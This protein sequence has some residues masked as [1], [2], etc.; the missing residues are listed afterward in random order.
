MI[1]WEVATALAIT[2]LVALTTHLFYRRP[3]APLWPALPL[4]FGV[5]LVFSVGDLIANT[6]AQNVPVRWGGMI[7]VY[8]GL[9]TIA[10]AW[11]VFTRAFAEMYGYAKIP[12]RSGLSTLLVVNALLWIGLITNPWHG[13]FLEPHAAA[14]SSYGPLWYMTAS[15]NYAALLA[16]IWVHLRAGLRVHDPVIRSQARFLVAAMA[17]PLV[18]NMVYVLSPQPLAYDPTALGFGLSCALFLF[19]VERRDLFV[20]EHVSLPSVL[21]DDADAILITTTHQRLLFANSAAEE[22]FGT[23]ALV[24][25][26]AIDGVL[27]QVVPSFSLSDPSPAGAD[28]GAEEHRF[29]SSKG[30]V[31]W[32]II[33]VS[34]VQRSRRVPAGMCLRLRDQTALRAARQEAEGHLALLKALNLATGEAILV[35]DASGEIRYINDAFNN[36]WNFSTED[37]RAM[38]QSLQ[39]EMGRLLL[40]PL[41]PSMQR[42]WH[43]RPEDFDA[44]SRET[45][46]LLLMDGRIVEVDSF[47]LMAEKGFRGRAWRLADVTKIRQESRAMIQSQKLEGLGV[48]A[49]GI[50]HDFNNLLVAIL[51]NAEI[52]RED[53]PPESVA[54]GPLADVE[55]AAVRASELTGQL[56]AYA[57]KNAFVHEDLDLSALIRDVTNLASVSVPKNIDVILKLQ[58]DLPLVRGGGAE[59]RQVVMNLMTNAADAIGE[60]GGRITFETGLGDSSP[61]PQAE[62]FVQHGETSDPAVHLRVADNGIGMDQRTLDKIFDPFF[63]TKFTGRGLGL[64]ATRGILDSHDGS[65]RIETALGL[66][67]VFSVMLPVE[68]AVEQPAAIADAREGPQRFWGRRVMVVDDEPS[69]RMVLKKRLKT[70]GFEVMTASS[71]EEGLELLASV[72][73]VVDLVI[74]D[75]TMPG[76]GGIETHG[77]IRVDHPELPILLSSGY[78]EE[79]LAT[80]QGGDPSRD[81]FIQ[82]P[83]RNNAL[84][85]QIE[86]LLS[87][88]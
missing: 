57:G 13:Q 36:L 22:L 81:A 11:W 60:D 4:V 59:L 49:G 10:P 33:E 64:A 32:V 77:R 44:V 15:V 61:M 82:K 66:G 16:A 55:A 28:V 31:S 20:L 21:N 18:M 46:D 14:R 53:L 23:T 35:K 67:S 68:K 17:V 26:A 74:L 34:Q 65:L 30:L 1:E 51:G 6:W 47:P 12:F 83:Y 87:N 2:L 39:W 42:L 8:T 54:H 48:L 88:F 40:E 86:G 38:G 45:S 24:P 76:I 63:T 52:A 43:I 19:A 85:A 27:E 69:V 5:A 70:A 37:V 62:A 75:L 71:G 79:A 73:A 29:E 56:L 7:L 25:G 9:L 80:L 41:G 72:G 84:L 50:A 58:A 78:P 3:P